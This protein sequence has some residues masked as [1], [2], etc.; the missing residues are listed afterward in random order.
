MTFRQRCHVW[1]TPEKSVREKATHFKD[2]Q[3]L[4]TGWEGER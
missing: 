2:K 3:A 4:S 1:V